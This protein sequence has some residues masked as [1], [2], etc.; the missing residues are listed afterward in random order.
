MLTILLGARITSAQEASPAASPVAGVDCT[1]VLGIGSPGDACVNIIQASPAAGEV[2]VYMDGTLVL[3]GLGYAQTSGVFAVVADFHAFAVVPAGSD[4][5]ETTPLVSFNHNF[6]FAG[7]DL[8]EF[9]LVGAAPPLFAEAHTVDLSELADDI[10]RVRVVHASADA[11]TVDVAVA[12]GDVLAEGLAFPR[13]SAY[14]ELPAGSV[15]L[16]VR[17]TGTTDVTLSA[18]GVELE[19]NTVVSAFVVGSVA[20]GSLAIVLTVY[21]LGGGVATPVPVPVASPA[22]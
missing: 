12:G 3:N 9:V 22:A 4:I 15:D 18:P 1:V 16:E 13:S 14:V 8:V 5:A 17:P 20:D 6:L 11:S 19:G 10:A 7:G 21:P 2:D